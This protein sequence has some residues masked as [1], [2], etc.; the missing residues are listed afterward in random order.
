MPKDRFLIAPYDNNS[1]L[2]TD[3]RPWL[4]S[5]Q[6]F[7]QLLNMYQYRGRIRKR[8]GSRYMADSKLLSRLRTVI[9]LVAGQ[10][11]IFAGTAAFTVPGTIFAIGQQFSVDTVLF[12]VVSNVAGPQQML[13]SDGLANVATFDIGT[14][15]YNITGVVVA[16]GTIVY[17]Y[18]ALPVMGLDTYDQLTV[19]LEVPVGFDTQWAYAWGASGWQR[20]AGGADI[21]VGT[22]S[23]FFWVANWRGV[24]P[25]DRILFVTNFDENDPNFMRYWNGAIWTVFQPAI[26]PINF[27]NSARIL[28]PFKNHL[29]AFNTFEGPNIAGQKQYPNRG[30]YSQNG[31]PLAIDAWREDIEGKG[32]AVDA[33]TNEAIVTVEFVRD[34][35]IVYFERSTWEFVFTGNQ[36]F[37]FIWQKINTE[38]GVESTFSI[39]PF[40]KVALGIGNTGIHACNGANVERIDLKIPQFV[41]DIKNAQGGLDRVHGIRDYT[42]EMIYWTLPV[43]TATDIQPYPTQVLIYNYKAGTWALNDDSITAFGYSQNLAGGITWDSSTVTWD[44]PA[45]WNSGAFQSDFRNVIGGNQEGYTFICD[46]NTTVNAAVIQITD[47]AITGIIQI[48][49]TAIDHNFREGDWI[50][51]QDITGTGT[52]PNI[53]GTIQ[54]VISSVGT[55]ITQNSFYVNVYD[56]S[57]IPFPTITGIY[58]GGGVISRVSKPDV[59]SKEYNFYAKDNRNAYVSQVNFLVDRTGTADAAAGSFLANFYVSTNINNMV[60]SAGTTG[61]LIGTSIIETSAYPNASFEAASTRLWHPVYLWADGN[62]IQVQITLNDLQMR[63]TAV[64]VAD[65]QIHAMLFIAQP[66]ASRLF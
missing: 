2:Q 4:I 15:A 64:R 21:W 66:T 37:P 53:N 42:P 31:S 29:V 41:F 59:R 45:S 52:I 57:G 43:D 25:F 35:L 49:I 63:S 38:L 11:T 46:S 16:N 8:F 7:A 50:Y 12:T 48:Q 27:L 5:D 56:A 9:N 10:G 18:P 47:I 19:N 20:L 62:V 34:R 26:S 28:V 58:S 22:N 36:S 55:P 32:N 23:D 61:S 44:D 6:A 65:L 14:G 40:D 33:A 30:R 54:Q 60:D 51:F 24:N 39:V 13:R 17:F 3:V 1:G